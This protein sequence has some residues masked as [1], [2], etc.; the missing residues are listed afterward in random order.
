[1][2]KEGLTEEAKR[3]KKP[4]PALIVLNGPGW[5]KFSRD[6]PLKGLK[7]Y[8]I[9]TTFEVAARRGDLAQ[10]IKLKNNEE[11]FGINTRK[12]LSEADE[13]MSN[14]KILNLKSQII[15]VWNCCLYR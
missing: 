13:R 14:L 5:K 11:W 8:G 2:E 6:A 9:N 12:E 7:E 3:L 4:A 10:V 1:M 15:Y